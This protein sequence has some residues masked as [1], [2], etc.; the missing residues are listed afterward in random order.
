[1]EASLARVSQSDLKT[2]RDVTA[3]GAR[4]TITEVHQSQVEDGRVDATDCVR[5][6]YPCFAVFILLDRRSIIVIYYFA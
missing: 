3:G 4:G 1:V 2:G 6:C 5:P